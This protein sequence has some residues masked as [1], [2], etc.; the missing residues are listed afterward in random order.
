[1]Q[2][3]VVSVASINIDE[4]YRVPHVV[5]PGETVSSTGLQ[6]SA[7]GK[8]ANA[9]VA[10][11]RAGAQVYVAGK[12]GSDGL[13]VRD[14]IAS[15]GADVSLVAV[16]ADTPT[17]RA[18]IQ[19]DPRGENAIFLF[20]GANHRLTADD[21]RQALAQC[22]PGDWLLLTNETTGVAEAIGHARRCGM[23]VLWNPTP[24]PADLVS[25]GLPLDLPDVLVLNEGELLALARQ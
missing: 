20:P 13:W 2:P 15:A 23:Q 8:G 7:G 17:G 11:A 9:S 10:A 4:V 1:M 6:R 25:S 22:G 3:K 21:V 12:I 19:V 18:V 24:M 14:V 5:Q 16:L